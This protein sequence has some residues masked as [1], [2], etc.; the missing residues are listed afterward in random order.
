LI[1]E[2]KLAAQGRTLDICVHGRAGGVIAMACVKK[3]RTRRRIVDSGRIPNSTDQGHIVV[4]APH[5]S[6][7][8]LSRRNLAVHWLLLFVMLCAVSVA[9]QESRQAE[10]GGL[11]MENLAKMK[12]ESVYGAS[13]FLQ[14]AVDAQAS[15]TVVT[16]EEIQKHG[17]RTLADVLRSVRSFYVINDRNYS[18]VGVRGLSR[19]GDYNARI[20][21]LLDGHRVNDNIFDGA[22]VGTEFPVDVD[23]IDRIEVIRGPNSSVYGTGAFVAVINVITK[24]GRD[25][26][27]TEL[28]T[29][30]GS[31]NT[32]KGRVSY[33]GRFDN[34]LETLLSGSFSNSQGHR[35][36]FFPEFDSPATNNGIAENADGDQS[37]SMFADIIYRDFNI[38]AVHASRTKHIPTASFGTVFNDSRTRTTDARSYLEIQYHHTF[39]SWETLGRASYDWYGYHGI[40][41][42]DYAGTGIPPNTEN[43]D[44]ANGAWWDFQGDTSK[45]FFKRHKVT[46]GTEFR[47]DVRQRQVNYDI[48]PYHLYFDDHRSSRV[49]ALY[50]QDDYSIRKN[51]AFVAGLR[52]D[53]HENFENT[54]SP[55]VGLHFAPKPN[56]V[57]KATYSRAFRAPNSFESFYAGNLSNTANPSLKPE[58]IRSW[59]LDFERRF[60]KAYYV[61]AAGFLNRID[62]LIEQKIDPLT[63]RPSYT[64]SAPVQTKGIE[65]ELGAKWP[66]GLEGAISYSLQDSRNVVAGDVL[67]NSP[68]HLTKVNLSL[69]LLQKKFFASVDAQY[70]SERRTI[71]QTELGGFFVM[72]LTFFTRKIT[73]KF[74]FSG[75]LYNLLDKRYADSGGLEHVQTSIPRDGRSFRIKLIYRPHWG[76]K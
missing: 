64:N 41:I 15:I 1:L 5:R 73:E 26:N 23:L 6:G 32:Y 14:K 60:G 7:S 46:L 72:N 58:R 75:G 8:R 71:A 70:V 31:W 40:Y 45:V 51:L 34:G 18:Y 55:R 22:Y 19:P 11:S 50:F 38:H 30:A 44:A 2:I 25:L 16:A 57:V 74:D 63:G 10:L 76:S 33:G 61:S 9:A 59:E 56:T 62:D 69:P 27:A 24:R 65:F 36:L 3:Q 17:Y 13:K 20:L 49:W 47:Q 68:K 29:E 42:Y 67:A 21:F 12:V 53:W 43:Y 66:S 35:R 28:S 54:L 4:G 48:Q 37:Y 52:S 39:G